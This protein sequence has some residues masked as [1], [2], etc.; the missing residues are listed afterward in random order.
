MWALLRL[1]D[2]TRQDGMGPQ[3]T[4]MKASWAG[5]E[6]D[7]EEEAWLDWMARYTEYSVIFP[8]VTAGGSQVSWA[9]SR[10]CRTRI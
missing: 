5:A 4:L 2:W 9:P 3:Y 10:F 7:P 1:D 8:D 6:P